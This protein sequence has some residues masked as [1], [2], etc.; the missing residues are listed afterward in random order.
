M[1]IQKLIA[2]AD[3]SWEKDLK[4]LGILSDSIAADELR[5]EIEAQS[6]ERR[7]SDIKQAAS[8]ILELG[9][10]VT[11]HKEN[12]VSQIRSLRAR[13]KELLK[14]IH[15]VEDA[16]NYGSRTLNYLPIALELGVIPVLCLPQGLS[17]ELL[18]VKPM[19]KVGVGDADEQA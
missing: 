10:S 9:R 17:S 15:L 7:S 8:Q 13:E 5:A 2:L 16:W 11:K 19:E 1:D 6:K 14:R 3:P 12:L 4:E 18:R